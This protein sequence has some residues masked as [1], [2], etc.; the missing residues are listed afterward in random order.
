MSRPILFRGVN[1]DVAVMIFLAALHIQK[2]LVN[3]AI[4]LYSYIL[5]VF[6]R[7]CAIDVMCK[8]FLI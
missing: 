4:F 3:V 7:K 6:N 1:L 2:L 5:S 8:L